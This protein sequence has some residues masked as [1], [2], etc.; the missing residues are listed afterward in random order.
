MDRLKGFPVICFICCL[1]L[2]GPAVRSQNIDID[3]L[4]SVNPRYPDAGFWKAASGSHIIVSSTASLGS[5]AYA[6]IKKDKELQYKSYELIIGIGINV[7]ATNGLKAIFRRPRPYVTYPNDVFILTSSRGTSFPSG[8]TS[9]A[10]ATA[11]SLTLTHKKWWVAVPA[12]LWAGCVGYSRMY[13]GKHYPSDLLG[14]AVVGVGS[15]FLSH[16]LSK[17]LFVQKEVNTHQTNT[18]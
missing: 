4:R 15:S 6:L 13:L 11:T 2:F 18:M 3:L 12:Y 17:K 16:W 9:L 10:F 8:H 7:I 14:G 1:H 5:L